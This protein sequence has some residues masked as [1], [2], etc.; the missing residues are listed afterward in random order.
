MFYLRD[1]GLGLKVKTRRPV[2]F[3]PGDVVEVSGFPKMEEGQAVLEQTTARLLR[4]EAPP[5]ALRPTLEALLDGTHNSDLVTISARLVDATVTDRKATLILQT[6][7]HLFRGLMDSPDSAGRSLPEKNSQVTVTGICVINELEELWFYRPRSFLLLVADATDL[8]LVQAPSWWTRERLSWALA[9]CG[10]VLLASA[11]WVWL[12]RRR[13]ERKRA[14]IEQQTRHAAALEERSRI[15]RELHDTLEQGLTGL[16][17]QMKAMETDF[18]A[19]PHPAHTRLK[20][21]RQMLRQ[22]RAL[23]RQAIGELR[24]EAVPAR[25][26]GLVEGLRRVAGSWNHSGALQVDLR[27]AGPVRPLPPHLESH[28][29]GIGTEAMTNAVKHGRAESIEVEL[30]FRPAAVCLRIKDNGTGFDVA[31]HLEEASGCFGLL[32]MRARARELC[33]EILIESRPGRGAEILVTVPA[34]VGPELAL[35]P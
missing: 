33:G 5:G 23:A 32:G 6:R 2:E 24:S 10:L 7:D 26:E 18:A 14:V 25:V 30:D 13:I 8:E 31:Q 21:A 15:A 29:L 19:A 22:S 3:R 4:T 28:L 12:L 9:T 17:L 20:F 11:G 34:A 27:I 35:P 1:A 16:S